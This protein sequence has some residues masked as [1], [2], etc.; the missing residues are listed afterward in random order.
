MLTSRSTVLPILLFGTSVLL[1]GKALC[2]FV[3]LS[4]TSADDA[5]RGGMPACHQKRAFQNRERLDADNSH[6]LSPPALPLFPFLTRSLDPAL[7]IAA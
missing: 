4:S 5:P 1:A 2:C 7:P 6:R 3:R